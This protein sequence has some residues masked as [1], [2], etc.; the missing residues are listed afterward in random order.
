MPFT[1]ASCGHQS[2]K[3]FGRCPHCGAWDSY[4]ETE[5]ARAPPR[6]ASWLGEEVRPLADMSLADRARIP[7]GMGELD[8][9]LGGGFVPG[10]V[11]LFGGEP[12]IGKSTLLL[13]VAHALA[14]KVG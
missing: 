14:E 10:G 13:Q 6:D 5:E 4:T 3:P 1:C 2:V 7:S 12:G 9:L 11:I 8:R